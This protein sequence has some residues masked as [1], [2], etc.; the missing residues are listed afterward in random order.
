MKILI[1]EDSEHL[2]R[3]LKKAVERAGHT[4]DSTLDGAEGLW[5]AESGVYDLILLDVMLPSLDGMTVLQRLRDQGLTTHV[6]MLTAKDQLQ[7]K[8]DGLNAGA[9]DYLVKPF[10]LDELL[11]RINAIMRRALPQKSTTISVGVLDVD[12]Q[13]KLAKVAGCLVDLTKRE[14]ALLEFFVKN[15]GKVIS[16]EQIEGA[17]YEPNAEIMSNAVNST[18]SVLRKKL[19][20]SGCDDVIQTKRGHGYVFGEQI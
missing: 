14:F 11:A 4:V 19:A 2:N 10:E 6:L 3:Y 12:L 1:V 20:K 8:L 7:D 18:I 13:A 9:D 15:Q 5:M 16:R 17:I